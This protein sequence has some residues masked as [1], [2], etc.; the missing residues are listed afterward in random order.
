[1]AR[2]P[3]VSGRDAARAFATVGYEIVRQRGSH[4][5][6][7]HS[8]GERLPLTVPDHRELKT[9]LLHRLIRD[10]GMTLEEFVEAL[11]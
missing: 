3:R 4:I 6:L 8:R 5:R 2:L 9:G 10:A 11:R 1:M 7:R